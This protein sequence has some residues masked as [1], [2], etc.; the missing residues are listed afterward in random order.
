MNKIAASLGIGL[1]AAIAVVLS[2]P[3]NESILWCIIHG[4]F[5]LVLCYISCH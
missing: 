2:Y 3:A 5:F 1:G 4:V